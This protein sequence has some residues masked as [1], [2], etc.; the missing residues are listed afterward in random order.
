MRYKKIVIGLFAVATLVSVTAQSPRPFGQIR[1]ASRLTQQPSFSLSLSPTQVQAGGTIHV[2]VKSQYPLDSSCGGQATSP[3]FIA[4]ITLNF[5]SHTVH[6]GDGP[7]ITEPGTY[8]VSVPCVSGSSLTAT[9]DIVGGPSPKPPTNTPP[10][11]VKPIGAPETGG[12]GT[13]LNP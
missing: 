6:A 5:T 2:E 10:K 13:S 7:V 3:G 9:F 1:L 8:L 4:P 12:G 11:V